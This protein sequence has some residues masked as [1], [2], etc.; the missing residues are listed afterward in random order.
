MKEF[1]PRDRLHADYL[2]NI[3]SHEEIGKNAYHFH[4]RLRQAI[5][6]KQHLALMEAIQTIED[7]LFPQLTLYKEDD[8]PEHLP[9]S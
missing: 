9:Q 6:P 5:S 7:I 2:V 1:E 8:T 3:S 4:V